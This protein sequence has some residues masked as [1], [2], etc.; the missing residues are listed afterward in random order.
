M[1]GIQAA[2]TANGD[3]EYIRYH[4]FEQVDYDRTMAWKAGTDRSGRIGVGI[5][6]LTT[7]GTDTVKENERLPAGKSVVVVKTEFKLVRET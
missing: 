1:R 5:T 2:R 3:Y 7:Y 6:E 4:T